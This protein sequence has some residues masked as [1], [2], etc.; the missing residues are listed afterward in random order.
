MDYRDEYEEEYED[1][2]DGEERE[3]RRPEKKYI[4]VCPRCQDKVVETEK[5][6]FCENR[7]CRFGIWKDNRYFTGKKHLLTGKE[8]EELLEN[9]S[10]HMKG[11]Y[12][13]RTDKYYDADVI[14]EEDGE[15]VRFRLEFNND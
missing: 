10:V 3:K 1:Y 4:G 15:K 13:E 6:F 12:S 8:V 11:L 2:E 7:A 9:G 5:G 14:M